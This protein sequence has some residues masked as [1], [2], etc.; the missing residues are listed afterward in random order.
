MADI[1]T[2][3][4][5]LAAAGSAPATDPIMSPAHDDPTSEGTQELE[6][7]VAVVDAFSSLTPSIL[8]HAGQCAHVIAMQIAERLAKAAANGSRLAVSAEP[9][10]LQTGNGPQ[11]VMEFRRL[12]PDQSPPRAQRW[13][14]YNVGMSPHLVGPDLPA[15]DSTEND[16]E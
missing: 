3:A 8:H 6:R 14:V 5:I 12:L 11:L 13:I 7:E 15:N 9:R 1:P 16:R 10:L 2:E 4:D